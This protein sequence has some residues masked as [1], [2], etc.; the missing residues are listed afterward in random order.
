M[1]RQELEQRTDNNPL[2]V[3]DLNRLNI[4]AFGVFL[5]FSFLI[6]A[7]YKVQILEFEK[8]SKIAKTQHKM[9][10][11]EP[12]KRGIFY[13]RS[14]CPSNPKAPIPLV[15]DLYRYHLHV[16]PYLIPQEHRLKFSRE[17]PQAST[18]ERSADCRLDPTR[19]WSRRMRSARA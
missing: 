17:I 6:L 10:V 11:E 7:F 2:V 12:C 3:K 1:S 19:D 8:W 9:A 18:G 14:L 5:L 4:L 16:D 13:G 15:M